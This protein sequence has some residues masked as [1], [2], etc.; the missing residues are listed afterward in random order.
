MNLCHEL[1]PCFH[2]IGCK[3]LLPQSLRCHW[4]DVSEDM[5]QSVVR[6]LLGVKN[7]V[8]PIAAQL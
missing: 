6:C 2:T 7:P 8:L 4:T 3:S 5:A 1:L